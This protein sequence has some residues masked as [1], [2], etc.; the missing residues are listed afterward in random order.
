MKKITITLTVL[1]TLFACNRWKV[2]K[3]NPDL[4]CHIKPGSSDGGISLVFRDNADILDMTFNLRISDKTIYCADN[5]SKRLLVL[6]KNG[7]LIRIIGPKSASTDKNYSEFDF[8]T[9]GEITDDKDGNIYVVDTDNNRIQKFD[10]EGKF[11]F[12]WGTSG[13]GK[14]QFNNPY[15]I[16]I[17]KE[18]YI[19]V[20]DQ[21]NYRIQKFSPQGE[22]L[23]EWGSKGEGD[24]QFDKPRGI[25]VDEYENVFVV[26]SGKN[27]RIQ[28]FDTEGKFLGKWGSKGTGE[29]QFDS[30]LGIAV[31]PY[32]YLYVADNYNNRIQK[33]DGKG[34]FI[35]KWG[36]EGNKEGEFFNPGGIVIDSA[37]RVYV[38]DTGNHR[39][40]V[41]VPEEK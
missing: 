10:G 40:Q 31:D 34:K 23:L 11:I 38:A 14:E 35:C 18:G 1:L 13:T 6:S 36:I 39:I 12:K 29:S 5:E 37:G 28:R 25:A 2:S 20:T 9:I 21:D 41:F 24:G 22:Y 16:A 4:L 33:F 15:G 30:P 8:S 3:L 26:D 17:D 32:G 7:D 27:N 19:Y